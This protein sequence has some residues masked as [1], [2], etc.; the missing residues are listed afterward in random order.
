VSTKPGQLQLHVAG[1]LAFS[2]RRAKLQL[3]H[4]WPWA[5]ELVAAFGRLKALPAAAG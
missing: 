3:Q 4:D 2:G 1:R 5:D